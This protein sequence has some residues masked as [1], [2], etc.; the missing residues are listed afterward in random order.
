MNNLFDSKQMRTLGALA[1]MA[2]IVALLSYAALT[3]TQ[4]RYA[5]PM[6]PTVTVTGEGEVLAVPDV[7]QFSFSVIGEGTDAAAAQDASGTKINDILAYLRAEGVADK[8]IKVEYYNLNPKY[9]WEQKP[10]PLGSYNCPPGEQIQDGFEVN[11]SI[12]VKV[13][14]TKKAPA[15]I[16][17][18]GERGA[19]NISSLNFTVDDTDALKTEARAEAIKDAQAKAEI[20]AEQLGVR[21]VRVTSYYEEG[22]YG[23]PYYKD[24]RMSL[25]VAEESSFGGAELPVGEQS[26]KVIV[27]VTYEIK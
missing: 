6:Y 20:L 17:G 27:N 21:L 9:R 16:A 22:D 8:D 24:A 26:T 5:D 13:R 23:E 10:C 15:L 25:S 7:G 2:V 18:V 11:Q 12:A 4:M 1:L 19:T 3:V 14:D